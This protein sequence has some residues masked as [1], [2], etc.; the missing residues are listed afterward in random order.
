MSDVN[1]Q[2]N[3]ALDGAAEGLVE[4]PSGQ[5]IESRFLFVDV[6]ALRAKQL[7]RGAKS[8][9]E[10]ATE[11]KRRRRHPSRHLRRVP[12]PP[13][14][15]AE[16]V[17]MRKCGS[18]WSSGSCPTSRRSS[19]PARAAGTGPAGSRLSCIEM[20]DLLVLG[21]LIARRPCRRRLSSGSSSSSAPDGVLAGPAAIP[22][23]APAHPPRVPPVPAFCASW[24][25]SPLWL[26]LVRHGPRRVGA[27]AVA[28]VL[29][30]Y[31][32]IAAMIGVLI[33]AVPFVLLGLLLWGSFRQRPVV[34]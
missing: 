6:A 30:W 15:K 12:R 27:A 18:A 10:P 24:C 23:A 25:C 8:R 16:R 4:H 3:G 29:V 33:P 11:A 19:T 22:V 17:A 32:L 34:A 9:L 2:S 14:I 31:R 21:G 5:P 26:G 7:R 1:V 20:I 13:Q 28:A